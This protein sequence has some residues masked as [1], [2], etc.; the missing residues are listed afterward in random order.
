MR[1][2]KDPYKGHY[3]RELLVQV[4]DWVTYMGIFLL[5]SFFLFEV[6]AHTHFFLLSSLGE[7]ISTNFANS[8]FSS[9]RYAGTL[10]N[11]HDESSPLVIP[12]SR[13]GTYR[14]RFTHMGY[15]VF[16]FSLFF[17]LYLSSYLLFF[18][19]Y[20]FFPFFSIPI[21]FE[22]LDIN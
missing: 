21:E 9:L 20:F 11:G 19:S 13:G 5:N 12:V 3:E 6:F 14:I 17:S 18:I 10:L 4:S 2:P 7:E 22:L 1:D 16:F 8:D 15:E